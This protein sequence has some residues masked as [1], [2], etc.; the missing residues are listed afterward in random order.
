M[1][2]GRIGK[3]GRVYPFHPYFDVQFRLRQVILCARSRDAL[4]HATIR[5]RTIRPRTSRP[6]TTIRLLTTRKGILATR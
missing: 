5:P 3:S 1:E 4:A 6:R 2:G